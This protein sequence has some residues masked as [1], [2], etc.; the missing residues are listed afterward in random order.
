MQRSAGPSTREIRIYP[1]L[2]LIPS[3]AIPMLRMIL[4]SASRMTRIPSRR[5]SH[6]GQV[7][8]LALPA[9]PGRFCIWAAGRCTGADP[10]VGVD[11]YTMSKQSTEIRSFARCIRNFSTAGMQEQAKH[12]LRPSPMTRRL[13]ATTAR[14]SSAASK[15]HFCTSTYLPGFSW[16]PA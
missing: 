10:Q 13:S 8:N 2:N 7:S 16:D 1:D 12:S 11:Q 3:T 14:L 15:L 6:L 9:K 5:G 4:P